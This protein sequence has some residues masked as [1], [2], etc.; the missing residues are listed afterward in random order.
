MPM[1]SLA[2]RTVQA[3]VAVFALAAVAFAQRPADREREL[4]EIIEREQAQNGPH[5]EGL[6][7]PLSRLAALYRDNGDDTLAVATIER[8]LQVVRANDGL[9]SLEQITPIQQLIAI[10]ESIGNAAAAWDLEQRLLTLARRHPDDLRTVPVL[11]DAAEKRVAILAR[12]QDGAVPPQI[13]LGCYSGWPQSKGRD[14]RLSSWSGAGA[15]SEI[16]RAILSDAQRHYADAI[17]IL[18][19]HRQYGSEELRVLETGIIDTILLG[20]VHAQSSLT[21]VQTEV[22]P[23]R[24]WAAALGEIARVQVPNPTGLPLVTG[25]SNSQS[26]DYRLGRESLVRLFAYELATPSP[27]FV[28]IEAFLQ[29]ADWDL[30]HGENTLATREYEQVYRLLGESSGRASIDALFAPQLPVVLPAHMPNPLA[31]AAGDTYIDVA[32]E[33]TQF[34]ESRKIEIVDATADATTADGDAL[35]ALIKRSRFRPRSN[36]GEPARTSPVVVRYYLN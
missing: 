23:W 31:T 5:S 7:G 19:R 30:L 14:G 2:G 12:Y 6:I 1:F 32:L 13:E 21:L 27:L 15:K 25:A 34:G 16:S 28:Q 22:E 4:F 18:L 26:F 29:I 17:A 24:T 20:E 35:V 36:D 10:E 33:V 11:R 9:H 3:A 8:V